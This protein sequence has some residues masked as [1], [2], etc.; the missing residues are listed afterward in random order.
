MA[1]LPVRY[2]GSQAS[3]DNAI[4]LSR[5]TEWLALGGEQYAGLGQ[6]VLSTDAE[7]LA[8][9]QVRELVLGPADG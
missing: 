7:E 4:R 5:K 3:E 8:L 2:P 1:L 6:R 9:L